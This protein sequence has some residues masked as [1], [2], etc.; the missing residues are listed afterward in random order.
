MNF[1]LELQILLVVRDICIGIQMTIDAHKM[2]L[3]W[4]RGPHMN[5]VSLIDPDQYMRVAFRSINFNND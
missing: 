4:K 5:L 2:N 3:A 1:L